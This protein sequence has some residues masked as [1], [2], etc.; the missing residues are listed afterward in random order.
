MADGYLYRSRVVWQDRRIFLYNPLHDYESIWWVA[1]GFVFC[2]NPEGLSDKKMKRG[3]Q[4]IFDPAKNPM[5][6]IE[7]IDEYL[8]PT[9]ATLAHELNSVRETFREAHKAF[10]AAFDASE[11]LSVAAVLKEHLDKLKAAA[12]PINAPLSKV[13]SKR[14]RDEVDQVAEAM[15]VLETSGEPFVGDAA[16]DFCESQTRARGLRSQSEKRKV[17]WGSSGVVDLTLN[18]NALGLER[19]VA[20]PNIDM[21]STKLTIPTHGIR[22]F[23]TWFR[24]DPIYRCL[25]RPNFSGASSPLRTFRQNH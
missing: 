9:L 17:V 25:I 22:T 23:A 8:P 15:E 21:L 6:R 3:R 13:L 14:T 12:G 19:L 10:E 16:T 20:T 1:L 2:C 7:S 4:K 5:R 24:C 18:S 11:M